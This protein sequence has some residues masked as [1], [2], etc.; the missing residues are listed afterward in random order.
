M[1]ECAPAGAVQHLKAADCLAAL[2]PALAGR[3]RLHGCAKPDRLT[4]V[5]AMIAPFNMSLVVAIDP[6]IYVDDI[7]GIVTGLDKIGARA[8]RD[9]CAQEFG[10]A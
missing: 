10:L 4:Q 2:D 6:N 1:A 7:V 3:L 8:R 5:A 9:W